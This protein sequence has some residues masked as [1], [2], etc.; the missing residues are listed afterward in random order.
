MAPP[1]GEEGAVNRVQYVPAASLPPFSGTEANVADAFELWY[2][3]LEQLDKDDNY[4]SATVWQAIRKSLRGAAV[5]PLAGYQAEVKQSDGTADVKAFMKI[6]KGLYGS[7]NVGSAQLEQF[8]AMRQRSGQSVAEWAMVLVGK[9]QTVAANVPNMFPRGSRSS[10]LKDRFWYGLADSKLQEALQGLKD[11][12]SN[13]KGTWDYFL[14]EARK[15]ESQLKGLP[16]SGGQ[17]G[18]ANRAQAVVG[19][20]TGGSPV[21]AEGENGSTGSDGKPP[22][23]KE[24]MATV[25][26]LENQVSSLTARVEQHSTSFPRARGPQGQVAPGRPSQQEAAE[27]GLC[28]RCGGDDH[29]IWECPY[30]RRQPSQTAK[31]QVQ[32]VAGMDAAPNWEME[33]MEQVQSVVG[34]GLGNGGG[35]QPRTS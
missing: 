29:F 14:G 19:E 31:V 35:D 27:K 5:S 21:G 20:A 30:Q 1:E 32:S 10:A 3:N 26:R 7:V 25:H 11:D 4:T 16:S 22:W 6:M 2:F 24:L 23:F 13:E 12:V 28:F 8:Y 15:L 9:Y 33:E 18:K 17:G 34:V